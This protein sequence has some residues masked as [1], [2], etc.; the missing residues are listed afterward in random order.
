MAEIVSLLIV[1]VLGSF[2]SLAIYFNNPNS[3]TNKAYTFLGFNI[4]AWSAILFF[5]LHPP[6]LTWQLSL[7]RISMAS[8]TSFA[9]AFFLLAHTFPSKQLLLSQPRLLV[10]IAATLLTMFIAQT[11][12]LFSGLNVQDGNISPIPGPGMVLFVI[13]AIGFDIAAVYL[14][15]KKYRHSSG[16]VRRQLF[17]ILLGMYLTL[18]LIIFNNFILVTIFNTSKL[19][20]L[21]YLFT[22]IFLG[23]TAYAIM[24]HRLLD[25]RLLVARSVSFALVTALLSLIY[26][27]LLF[28][29]STAVSTTYQLPVYIL[30]A[31]V[32]AYT[33]RPLQVYI[34]KLT[35]DIFHK[36]AYSSETL[37]EELG[38][39]IRSTLSLNKLLKDVVSYLNETMRVSSSG[40]IVLAEKE[41]YT[42]EIQGFPESF[43]L[44]LS[45]IELL[46]R[47]AKH[48][49]LIFDEMPE[50]DAKEIMRQH[51][52]SIVIPMT[53]KNSLYGIVVF[54]QKSS[55]DIY[56]TQ[57]IDVLE[58]FAPQISIAIQNSLAY[59]QI[60]HFNITLKE[61]V[62]RATKDLKLANR[63]LRHLDKLKD[64]FVF[65]ATHELKNPVTAMRGYMSMIQEGIFGPIPDKM[66]S[67]LNQIQTSNQQLVDLVNDLLQ[68]ARSEAK[69]L[70]IHTET[71]DITQTVEIV[72]E[73]LKPLISQKG[74]KF[75]HEVPD[76]IMVK[77]DPSRLKEIINNLISN[78]I[79]YSE[80]GTI[81]VSYHVS[82]GVVETRVKDQGYGISREDQKK[83]FTRFYRVE[84]EAAKGIPGTG[85]GLFI[86]KQLIEKMGGHIWIESEK[87]VGSTFFFTLPFVKQ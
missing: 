43:T 51:N 4:V 26:G 27:S 25:I 59:D 40:I 15:M 3:A 77:A 44:P 18:G 32:L 37:L 57:D 56:S 39:I 2:L 86:V 36:E 71:V 63:H 29:L 45:S 84:E 1:V 22:L 48:S 9:F 19:M 46:G 80:K 79:K 75:I 16:L 20:P 76:H 53:V 50:S 31:L 69:T 78:A 6:D 28:A 67:P 70:T 30:I 8:S 21:G 7:I 60:R 11:P 47:N 10:S 49:L 73:N 34:Q 74:L 87:G 14:L 72:K 35:D 61:E 85:L 54:G 52:L 5:S 42:Q 83:L 33:F 58:I 24:R 13:V 81:S 23:A 12:L 17:Y 66:K 62:D 68:I 65:I 64:E 38:A 55:G 41:I 82:D